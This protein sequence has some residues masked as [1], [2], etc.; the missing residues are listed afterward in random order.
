MEEP[1]KAMRAQENVRAGT[2]LPQKQLTSAAKKPP[3]CKKTAKG[4]HPFINQ[5]AQVLGQCVQ[6]PVTLG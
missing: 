6:L 2:E 3:T 4:T 1:D 5:L